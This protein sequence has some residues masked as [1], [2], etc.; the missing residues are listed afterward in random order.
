MIPTLPDPARADTGAGEAW[1]WEES[2]TSNHRSIIPLKSIE[3]S[4]GHVIKRSPYTPYS[5]YLR[6]TI[7]GVVGR[8]EIVGVIEYLLVRR[9]VIQY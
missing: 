2:I 8:I 5:I 3:Y 6:G 1:H 7:I 4:F 9:I